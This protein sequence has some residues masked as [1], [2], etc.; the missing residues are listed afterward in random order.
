M[1][2]ILVILFLFIVQYTFCQTKVGG[3]VLDSAGEPVSFANVLFKD[4]SEGTITN[5]NGRFYMESE[6]TYTTLLVSFIGYETKEI[7]LEAKVTYDM[8]IVLEESS[9]QLDEVVVYFGKTDK[10]NNPAIDILKKIWAKKR[11]NGVH[12]FKQYQFDKYEKV[13]FDLNTIDSALMK[14]RVF[15]GLEF[16][17]NDLDTSRI[18]GKTYL[19]IFLNETFS[20]VYGDNVKALVKEDVLG[21]KNSGFSN[22][23]AIIAFIADLYSDYDIYDNYLKFFDKSFTSPLSRT[24]VDTYNYVLADSAFIDNK[25][26]YNIIYYPRRKN[27]LTFKGDFWVNDTTYAVKNINLAVTKSANINWVKE[28]YIEQEFDVVNDSVFLLTRDYMLSD[29]SF[30]KKENSRGVYG[31]R[32]TVYGDY[33]FNQPKP[34]EFYK[35]KTDPFDPMVLN[36]EDDFWEA[37]RL[38]SLNADEKGIYKLLDTLKTV[39][40]F[41][42]YYNIVSILGSGYVEID[43]WNLDLGDVYSIFGYNEAEGVRLRVGARTYFGQND[44]WRLQAYLAYG[45][46]DDKFKYGISG[47]WLVDKKSRFIISGGKRR[48]IEQLGISLT[49]TTDVL[50]RSIASSSV[51]TVGSNNRLTNIDL[52]TFNLELEPITNFRVGVGGSYRTLSSALPNAFGLDYIDPTSPTGISSEINQ[53][54]LSTILIYTP[55]KKT[56][57]SG[58]ERRDVNDNYSTLFLSYTNGLKNFLDSDFDYKKV[59]FSYTQ[60][61]QV[62]G[63]GR[64]LTTVEIGKTYGEVPLGLLNAIPGNQTFFSVY[65]TFSNLDF[66]EFVTDTYVS[67]HLEH[68]FNGRFFSRIPFMRKWNLREI[69]GLRGVWGELSDENRALSAPANI[70]LIAPDDKIYWEYSVGVG[71]IFKILRIDFNF[72]GNYLENPGARSFGVTGSFGFLF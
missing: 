23:Q 18:T 69:I 71:N 37:N 19:P 38:E 20:K 13:E 22:N 15:R 11:K 26:C 14:S 64:L 63:L 53:F 61:W 44:P 45:F 10:K 27:E 51:L 24:G 72:R 43:K 39:P 34:N 5:D 40:K 60:P 59:Q 55:G 7:S 6:N 29:F 21:S 66:Y 58:V 70:P 33:K 4:S 28:I 1:A 42:S 46:G 48:D 32:T 16:V 65:N 57:G 12:M 41:K 3:I 17:F 56:I 54:D 30:N 52:S 47:K 25:W 36:K 67:A 2:R 62:G 35:A 68:N 49:A 9:E 50:G 8:N 31:K